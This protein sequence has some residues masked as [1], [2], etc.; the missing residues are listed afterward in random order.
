MQKGSAEL[1]RSHSGTLSL[2]TEDFRVKQK[3][4]FLKP[5]FGVWTENPE[6]KKEKSL[7][8]NPFSCFTQTTDFF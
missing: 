5:S 6:K 7:L 4:G 3:L 2:K 8:V 1:I